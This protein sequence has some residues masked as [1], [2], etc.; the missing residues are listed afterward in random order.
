MSGIEEPGHA[1]EK[2]ATGIR[3]HKWARDENRE[4]YCACNPTGSG[5]MKRMWDV[6]LNIGLTVKKVVAP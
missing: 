6:I 3:R 2:W 5:Y 4:R 1:N